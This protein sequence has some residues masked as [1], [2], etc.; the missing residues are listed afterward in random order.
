ML[1]HYGSI[2]FSL[3]DCKNDEYARLLNLLHVN[4]EKS[5]VVAKNLLCEKAGLGGHFNEVKGKVEV[6]SIKHL[7]GKGMEITMIGRTKEIEKRTECFFKSRKIQVFS[8]ALFPLASR[9]SAPEF[10]GIRISVC[11]IF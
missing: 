1:S 3:V 9:F 5:V 2:D 4:P 8:A 10:S 6:S 7:I 11:I